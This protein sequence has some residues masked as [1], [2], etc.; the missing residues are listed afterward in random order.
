MTDDM[1]LAA[2]EGLADYVSQERMDAGNIYPDLGEAL[3]RWLPA[4]ACRS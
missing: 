1:L 2:A 3:P 4:L